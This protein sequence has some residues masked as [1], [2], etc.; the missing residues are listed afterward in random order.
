MPREHRYQC[1]NSE[2]TRAV[3]EDRTAESNA[4][5][6]YSSAFASVGAVARHAGYSPRLARCLS[7][8]HEAARP[9]S[10]QEIAESVA[11]PVSTCHR[12][13]QSLD[14]AGYVYKEGRSTVRRRARRALCRSS[15]H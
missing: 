6:R 11:L 8:L 7:H 10:L 3:D 12:L 13:L 15:I 2:T 4:E 9:L 14:L 1:D 5:R